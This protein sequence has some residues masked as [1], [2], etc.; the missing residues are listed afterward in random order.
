MT[1]ANATLLLNVTKDEEND[2][3]YVIIAYVR[4]AQKSGL[5]VEGYVDG[6]R[7]EMRIKYDQITLHTCMKFSNN[8]NLKR[9]VN[10][11]RV[12]VEIQVLLSK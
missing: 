11:R 12:K 1:Q 10:G 9:K 4:R 6:C 2:L 7:R 3:K 8:K 5:Q